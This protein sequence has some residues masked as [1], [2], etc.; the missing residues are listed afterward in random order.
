MNNSWLTAGSQARGHEGSPC[1]AGDCLSHPERK[2]DYRE[3]GA[4]HFDGID[5]PNPLILGQPGC[6]P[7]NLG[8]RS[9][10]SMDEKLIDI[11][12]GAEANGRDQ[13]HGPATTGPM[14]IK[15]QL[16]LP[17]V[18]RFFAFIRSGDL[19]CDRNASYSAKNA[20]STSRSLR[21]LGSAR[22][23]LSPNSQALARVYKT[24]ACRTS[25]GTIAA[26]GSSTRRFR[27]PSAVRL[28]KTSKSGKCKPS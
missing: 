23:G 10:S 17:A 7:R 12:A 20:A 3:L 9:L 11:Q 1:T 5:E 4:D 15:N 6:P 14:A 24:F 26:R 19:F 18:Q 25:S 21:H 8:S 28:T 13:R 27:A 22:R 16:W 2:E